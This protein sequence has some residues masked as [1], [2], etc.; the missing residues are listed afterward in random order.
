MMSLRMGGLRAWTSNS[1][2][3]RALGRSLRTPVRKL[4]HPVRTGWGVHVLNRVHGGKAFISASSSSPPPVSEVLRLLDKAIKGDSKDVDAMDKLHQ[5]I[6]QEMKEGAKSQDISLVA[7]ILSSL[8]FAGHRDERKAEELLEH[9]LGQGDAM[10]MFYLARMHLVKNEKEEPDPVFGEDEQLSDDLLNTSHLE[11]NAEKAK[12]VKKQILLLIK[13]VRIGK[14]EGAPVKSFK[15]VKQQETDDMVEWKPDMQKGLALLAQSAELGNADAQVMLGNLKVSGEFVQLLPSHKS[16]VVAG[17]IVEVEPVLSRQE[18]DPKLVLEDGVKL[19]ELAAAQ[20]TRTPG[21][22][23]GCSTLTTGT[24]NAEE[25]S[26]GMPS[27]VFAACRRRQIAATAAPYGLRLLEEASNRDHPAASYHVAMLMREEGKE[28]DMKKFLSK[29]AGLG[30]AEALFCLGD[31]HFH[32]SDGFQMDH[33]KAFRFFQEAARLQHSAA[34]CCVGVMCYNGFGV[35]KDVN[36]AFLAY[37]RSAELGN[38]EAMRNLAAMHLSGEGCEKNEATA[39][40][41]LKVVEEA[42]AEASQPQ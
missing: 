7:G 20:G 3:S 18:T 24:R 29:A 23:W 41:L 32:G 14:R 16:K 30:D 38:I 40:Y 4:G 31:M 12:K 11:L 28:E 42:E 15:T 25:T 2:W 39:R 36:K 21:T 37:Q 19:Y 6:E 27:N 17:N 34:M 10:A 33:P 1:F 9:A 22:T 8:E 13:E 35:K 5:R 26:D